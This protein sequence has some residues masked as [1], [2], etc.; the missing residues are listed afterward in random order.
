MYHPF[1]QSDQGAYIFPGDGNHISVSRLE[2][3][4]D[5]AYFAVMIMR[6]FKE[7]IDFP[8]S[9]GLLLSDRLCRKLERKTSATL[10]GRIADG[11]VS[12]VMRWT[13]L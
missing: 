3:G 10:G 11:V 7:Q 5:F 8:V 9:G 13:Y 12:M 4:T 2:L 6:V 1:L